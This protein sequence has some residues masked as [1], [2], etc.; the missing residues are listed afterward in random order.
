MKQKRIK[1]EKEVQVLE[2]ASRL[3]F[4]INPFV[5]TYAWIEGEVSS[6]PLEGGQPASKAA[7]R[8]SAAAGGRV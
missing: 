4:L 8:F 6:R 7:G 5:R 1:Q 3:L 2:V